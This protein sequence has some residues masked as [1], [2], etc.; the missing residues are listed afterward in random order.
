MPTNR[1]I[2]EFA[3]QNALR[4][5]R[6]GRK[7]A[8]R[9]W[10]L[11]AIS[12]CPE[13]EEPWLI[14]AGVASPEGSLQYYQE[15]LKINPESERGPEGVIRSS[16]ADATDQPEPDLCLFLP[17]TVNHLSN[18]PPRQAPLFRAK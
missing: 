16:Q 8:G 2:A 6:E 14:M 17:R 9:S 1:A 5:L 11:R 4:E 15:A 3:I 7:Q 12:F 10:A 13:L 18:Q